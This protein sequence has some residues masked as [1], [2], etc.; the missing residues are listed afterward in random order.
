MPAAVASWESALETQRHAWALSAIGGMQLRAPGH[1]NVVAGLMNLQEAFQGNTSCPLTAV[2]LGCVF[3]RTGR[4]QQA[5]RM[6]K[7]ATDLLD[8]LKEVFPLSSTIP[9]CTSVAAVN[10]ARCRAREQI[11]DVKPLP[12]LNPSQDVQSRV[13]CAMV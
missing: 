11:N 2:R 6:F 8:V 7:Y 1:M 5:Y 4:I 10:M 9:L 12:I 13:L 3:E